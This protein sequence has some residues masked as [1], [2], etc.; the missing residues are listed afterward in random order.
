MRLPCFAYC[1][2]CVIAGR[3]VE[4]AG[5][6][7]AIWAS[8][9]YIPI[10]ECI[11]IL[12]RIMTGR[13]MTGRI[14]GRLAGRITGTIGGWGAEGV[15]WNGAIGGWGAKGVGWNGAIGDWGGKGDGGTEL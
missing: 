9:V 10:T 6:C 12:R 7:R 1:F 15:G 14:T 13:I 4:E 11:I 5:V 2:V 3:F 8:P